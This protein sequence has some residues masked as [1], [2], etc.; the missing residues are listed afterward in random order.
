M[1]KASKYKI[2]DTQ[3]PHFGEKIK[4]VPDSFGGFTA[5]DMRHLG[6]HYEPEQLREIS[7]KHAAYFGIHINRFGIFLFG[8][9]YIKYHSYQFGI[10]VDF[11]N[12]WDAY[13]D[14]EMRVACF[15]IG[16]RFVWMKKQD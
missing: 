9:E 7:E 15:G 12:S 6:Q 8:R 10:G 1:E 2:I 11:I 13:L 16:V 3:N 4:A 5:V 14:V